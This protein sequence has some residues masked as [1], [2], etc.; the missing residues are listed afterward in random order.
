[1]V[2]VGLDGYAPSTSSMSMRH[3]TIELKAPVNFSSPKS[4]STV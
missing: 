1:M 2:M 4:F 3:S